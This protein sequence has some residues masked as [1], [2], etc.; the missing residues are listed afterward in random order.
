MVWAQ[1]K[2]IST[3]YNQYSYGKGS[4]KADT[5]AK[6]GKKQKMTEEQV[7]TG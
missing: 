4:N 1:Q 6:V 5:F 3:F 7:N 2:I